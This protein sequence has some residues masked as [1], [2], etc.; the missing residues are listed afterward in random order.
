MMPGGA[1]AKS[2]L[3]LALGGTPVAAGELAKEGSFDIRPCFSNEVKILK[4]DDAHVGWAFNGTGPIRSNVPEGP[5]DEMW[6]SCVGSGGVVAGQRHLDMWCDYVDTAGYLHTNFALRRGGEYVGLVAPDG[7]VV[8]Q[9]GPDGAEFPEQ[10]ANVSYGVAQKSVVVD[11][12]PDRGPLIFP[13]RQQI[14]QG[15]GIQYGTG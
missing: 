11:G 2:V 8:S 13:V 4:F 12:R 1:V 6:Q 14:G 5:F 9:Y 3:M 7:Q 15:G 10:L